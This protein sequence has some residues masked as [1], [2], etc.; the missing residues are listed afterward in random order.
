MNSIL[1]PFGDPVA[2]KGDEDDQTDHLGTGA[3]SR[4]CW[5][6]AAR[7]GLILDVDGDEGNRKPGTKGGRQNT[8][9][10]ADEE[11]MSERPRNVHGLLQH[12][13]AK[14]DAWDP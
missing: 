13:D 3:I 9:D 12:D 1:Q 8:S 2:R 4:T 11:D 14:R 7:C 5:V 6:G 10:G